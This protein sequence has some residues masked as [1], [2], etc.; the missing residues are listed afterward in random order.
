MFSPS[1]NPIFTNA[2]QMLITGSTYTGRI[3]NFRRKVTTYTNKCIIL[4][5]EISQTRGD[6]IKQYKERLDDDDDYYYY[7]YNDGDDDDDYDDDDDDDNYD[8]DYDDDDDDDDD[9]S[10]DENLEERIR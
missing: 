6:I 8:Y 3:V 4:Y 5:E 7:Y 9:D 1:Q 2:K 10:D